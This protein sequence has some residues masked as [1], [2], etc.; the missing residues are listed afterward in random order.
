M[1]S[2]SEAAIVTPSG[3]VPGSPTSGTSGVPSRGRQP[4]QR[5]GEHLGG[6]GQRACRSPAPRRSRCRTRWRAG[7]GCAPRRRGAGDVLDRRLGSAEPA[8]GAV[9]CRPGCG[10]C[11]PARDTLVWSVAGHHGGR[12]PLVVGRCV[13]AEQSLD[14]LGLGPG[15]G[16]DIAVDVDEGAEQ[17]RVFDREV[18]CTGAVPVDQPTT[19][20]LA[21]PG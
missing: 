5:G 14:G 9:R 11:K 10:H 18:Q 4:G 2:S 21:G 3:R 16:R 12:I 1:S 15:V 6:N 13:P 19:P 17:F 7:T 20:Q 8:T